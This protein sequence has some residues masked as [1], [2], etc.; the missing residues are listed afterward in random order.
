MNEEKQQISVQTEV[1]KPVEIVWK[2][3]TETKHVM[4]WNFAS[5]D[6]HCP[7]AE[8][9]LEVGGVFTYTMA[10]KDGS[11]SFDFEGKYSAVEHLKLIEYSMPDAR[12]VSIK[13]EDLGEK[14]RVTE[15]FDPEDMHPI[16]F[17]Q[18]GWQAILDNFRKYTETI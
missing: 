4:N 13:F 8:N 6:W 15:I 17:Q 9:N 5:D 1:N 2:S 14:T 12:F 7:K 3:F 10:A 16:E 18:A 11:M